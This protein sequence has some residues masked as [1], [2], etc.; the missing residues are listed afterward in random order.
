MQLIGKITGLLGLIAALAA[1]IAT[2]VA[3]RDWE[4][5]VSP[6]FM[7]PTTNGKFGVGRYETEV[8]D[9][10]ADLFSKLNWGVFGAVEANNGDWGVN[11]DVNYVNIDASPDDRRLSVNGH[12]AAYTGIILK[13]IHEYAWACAGVRY[14]D[15]G[16]DLECR[17]GCN[18][19]LLPGSTP[20]ER[21]GNKGWFEPLVGI[22]AELPFNEKLDLTVTADLGGFGAGSK[23]SANVWPQLGLH[24]ARASKLLIGYRIIY[25]DYDQGVGRDR[26]LYDVAT[27]GPTI[28]LEFRF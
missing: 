15:F 3:A 26:F 21:R 20:A 19:P 28:G 10:P 9:S 13:R 5:I 11:F 8:A 12:Q 27:F 4:I 16:L 14:S 23:I 17:N 24:I 22:R 6:Y 18:L 7:L 1:G 2:P 25:V